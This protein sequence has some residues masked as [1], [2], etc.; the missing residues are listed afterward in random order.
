MGKKSRNTRQKELIESVAG[1]MEN[2]FTADDLYKSAA[3]KEKGIGIATVY[4]C[5]KLLC[6]KGVLHSY[7]C[8]RRKVYSNKSSNHCHFICHKCGKSEHFDVRNLDFLK[9]VVDAD[10]CHFQL[11]VYGLCRKCSENDARQSE[12]KC[13][14]PDLNRKVTQRCA[15]ITQSP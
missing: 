5:V 8:G 1:T 9:E 7:K 12:K 6:E 11:D 10:V 15:E 2:I 3:G 4:R 13:N 14:E